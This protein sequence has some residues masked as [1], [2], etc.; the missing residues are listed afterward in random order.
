MKYRFE[1]IVFK[2]GQCMISGFALGNDP[3]AVLSY[4]VMDEYDNVIKADIRKLVRNDVSN[5]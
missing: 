5:K 1:S 3:D 4:T 2:D